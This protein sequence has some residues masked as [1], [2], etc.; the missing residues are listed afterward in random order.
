[1]SASL[2]ERLRDGTGLRL[3]QKY[4]DVFR[5][6]KQGDQTYT[7]T[8][9]SV[10]SSTATQDVRGKSFSR[11]ARFD[12][13]EL[14]ET[15]EVEIYLTASGINFAPKVGMTIASPPSTGAAFKITR[16]QAIPESGTV[17]LFRLLAQK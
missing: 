6:T 12:D 13:P 8:T 16:V 2:F 14:A 11:D 17:V 1:M 9:G 3:L 7:P 15:T 5:V 4:G 10:T